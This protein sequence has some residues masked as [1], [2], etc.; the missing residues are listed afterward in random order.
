MP[1]FADLDYD[2]VCPYRNG[3]PY[4]EGLST[5]WVFEEYKQSGFLVGDYES[6]LEQLREQLDEADRR[7]RQ[8][9]AENHQ[10][11]NQLH[12]LHRRQF[13]GRKAPALAQ[14]DCPLAQPK[15]R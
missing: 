2:F 10:L 3:C 9:E 5:S 8:L 11:K 14:P 13:Q 12:T 1:T 15:K 4:L 6:Q 7:I